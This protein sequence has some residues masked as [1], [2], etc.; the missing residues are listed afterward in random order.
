M[1]NEDTR[2]GE[3]LSKIQLLPMVFHIH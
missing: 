1:G 2:N 3:V